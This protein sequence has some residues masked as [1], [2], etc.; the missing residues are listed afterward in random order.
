MKYDLI[1]GNPQVG[2]GCEGVR[3]LRGGLYQF[4]CTLLCSPSPLTGRAS[5]AHTIAFLGEVG[6]LLPE[7]GGS[8]KNLLLG[9]GCQKRGTRVNKGSLGVNRGVTW[10][11]PARLTG[12]ALLESLSPVHLRR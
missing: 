4:V 7:C 6:Q 5:W 3:G 11:L 2:Y 10:T 1:I 12:L 8:D 9:P